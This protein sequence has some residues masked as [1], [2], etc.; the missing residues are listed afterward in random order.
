MTDKPHKREATPLPEQIA[1][2]REKLARMRE[3]GIFITGNTIL[4]NLSCIAHTQED[5]DATI[6]AVGNALEDI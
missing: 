6:N 4:H 1:V 3:Q 2:R 5:I